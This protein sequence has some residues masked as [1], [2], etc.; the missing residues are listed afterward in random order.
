[1]GNT[2]FWTGP[3][4]AGLLTW[5]ALR[6]LQPV[7]TRLDLFDH[8][9]GRKDHD[10]PTPVTGGLA[11]ALGAM[12]V[13][14][15]LIDEPGWTFAGFLLGGSL[16]VA[17]GLLDDKYDLPWWVR[18]GVQVLATLCMI[19]IGGVQVERLGPVFGFGD[20]ALGAL[21]VPFTVFATVGLINAIN[22]IDGADG[23]AGSLV[24]TA[25]VMLAAAALYAGND[26]L[27]SLIA[28]LGGAVAGFLAY[29]L[30]LPWRP[31]A[32]LFMGN[33][34]SAFL[35][36]A[37]AWAAFRLTQN[38]LHEVSPVLALWLVP[39]PVMDTLVLMMR[40]VRHRKSPFLADRNHI[41]HLML[42]AGIGPTR[43]ALMLSLFSALCGFLAAVSQRQLD[44]PEP[45]LLA[46]FVLLCVAWF[47]L[48]RQRDRAVSFLARFR[49]SWPSW[50]G[51]RWAESHDEP[52]LSGE[53]G[54]KPKARARR[55]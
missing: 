19:Y 14:Y 30:R 4:V 42:E 34:G 25:L 32:S 50:V 39:I 43:T 23:L 31:R 36:F 11:M 35:G 8:P 52:E 55:S 2:I 44:L 17:V 51:G 48:T 38:P 49:W 16:L 24:L 26:A 46:A 5:I 20:S 6:L 54:D 28:V 3:L 29:N 40:R 18:I 1:M 13:S 37:I 27:A 47:W 15:F 7:A 9:K 22:M 21:S 10:Q 53:A 45:F 33:A 12:V 41:H